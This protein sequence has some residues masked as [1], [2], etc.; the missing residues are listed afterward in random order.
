MCVVVGA[1]ISLIE[2]VIKLLILDIDADIV[3]RVFI[4]LERVFLRV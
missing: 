4:L 1:L 2:E 3:V